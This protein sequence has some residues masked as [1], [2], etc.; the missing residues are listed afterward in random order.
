MLI[1]K[2]AEANLYL[3]EWHG[4]KVIIK[5]RVSKRYR[6][7]QLDSKI[8]HYR[9][10]HETQLIHKAKKA[11]VPTPT[12]FMLDITNS[13]IYMEFIKGEEVKK[14]LDYISSEKRHRLCRHIGTLI[15]LLHNNG[16]I[17]GDLTTSNMILTP[18]DKVVFLDFGLG[19]QQKEIESRGVDLHL[20][21]RAFKSIHYNYAEESFEAVIEGYCRVVGVKENTSVLDKLTAIEK[22][23]RYVSER[24]TKW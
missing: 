7:P 23:G 5:H 8:R 24:K 6:V 2:G 22:R 1:K 21:K 15:G 18:Y 19:V 4:V 14:V 20:L 12:I 9:T 11:G 17:H 13:T 10:I 3:E 16:I